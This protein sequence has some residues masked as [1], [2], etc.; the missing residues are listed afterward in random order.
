MK[1]SNIPRRLAQIAHYA[2]LAH[3]NSDYP[4]LIA[5]GVAR[6]H[7]FVEGDFLGR[8]GHRFYPKLTFRLAQLGGMRVS[9]DPAEREQMI[10]F[11]E[12]ALPPRAY[13]IGL[14]FAPDAIFDCGGH[15]GLFC[16]SAAHRYP[17][18]PITTFE[19]NPRNLNYLRRNVELNK[20]NA[21][22]VDA[23]VSIA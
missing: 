18:V 7:P 16:L 1:V 9:L 10:V 8:L 21:T 6:H 11:E 15:I 14:P 22:V 13:D 19:P 4:P 23:A 2:S 20:L 5:L 3:T 12:I 17:G